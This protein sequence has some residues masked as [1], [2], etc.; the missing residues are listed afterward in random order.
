MAEKRRHKRFVRRL[1]V[2]FGENDLSR[3]AFV[4]DISLGGLFVVSHQLPP[5]GVRV[6]LQVVQDS[7]RSVY[8]EA[9]VRRQKIIPVELRQLERSGFGAE[10]LRPEELVPELVP[11]VTQGNRFELVFES[12]SKLKSAFSEEIRVGGVFL[13]TERL[14][15]RDSEVVVEVRLAF[16]RQ[17]FDFEGKVVHVSSGGGGSPKGIA[18]SFFNPK[19]VVDTLSPFL[20]AKG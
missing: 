9:V 10:F 6:H 13:R 18:I 8:F 15:Q 5:V 2:R 1:A 12:P 3:T 20:E 4:G 7:G 14:L 19:K 17:K 16:A 11:Q